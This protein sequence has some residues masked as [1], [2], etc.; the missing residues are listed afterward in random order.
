MHRDLSQ[1]FT[2]NA[3][4]HTLNLTYFAVYR[5]HAKCW[6]NILHKRPYLGT[7]I[8]IY[9][10]QPRPKGSRISL[11]SEWDEMQDR[12]R[13]CWVVPPE[14]FLVY[15]LLWGPVRICIRPRCPRHYLVV[16][17]IKSSFLLSLRRNQGGLN[18]EIWCSNSACPYWLSPMQVA[19]LLWVFKNLVLWTLSPLS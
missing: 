1:C 9:S 3:N 18:C 7:Y 2:R 12:N 6:Q 8:P 4:Y 13:V 15:L 14:R 11:A 16:R 19:A 17:K 5:S 10:C